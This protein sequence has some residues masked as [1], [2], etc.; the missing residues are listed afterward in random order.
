MLGNLNLY[1]S[2]FL[3]IPLLLNCEYKLYKLQDARVKLLLTSVL[4]AIFTHTYIYI[5]MYFIRKN[6]GNPDDDL[7]NKKTNLKKVSE[8]GVFF[9]N[10]T[11][12]ICPPF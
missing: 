9:L 8:K 10:G 3:G 11:T 12:L 7:I 5:S 2:D 6:G 1:S 4:F